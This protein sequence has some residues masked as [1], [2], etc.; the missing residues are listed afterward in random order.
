MNFTVHEHNGVAELAIEGNIL[1]ES[2][3]VLK[4][5]FNDLIENGK[6]QIVLNMAQSN[7][8]S[9]LC[10][11]VIVDVK[12]RLVQSKGDLKI[13]NVNR[14]IRNL[15]EITNLV[16]KIELFDSVEEAVASFLIKR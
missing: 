15:L 3:D 14:L 6:V 12:N 5:R 4:E 2:V 13:A 8:V 11:A 10:L 9:S 16:K 7:Y 1:Q